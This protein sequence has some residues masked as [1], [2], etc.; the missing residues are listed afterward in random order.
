MKERSEITAEEVERIEKMS[1]EEYTSY[2]FDNI[3]KN[4]QEHG[5]PVDL[6]AADKWAKAICEVCDHLDAI[7]QLSP[8]QTADAK[9]AGVYAIGFAMYAQALISFA[10]WAQRQMTQA[11]LVT[12]LSYAV[13]EGPVA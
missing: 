5:L 11:Q 8:G 3:I 2:L 7:K 1:S 4:T 6:I 10:K 9:Q 12:V 13:K